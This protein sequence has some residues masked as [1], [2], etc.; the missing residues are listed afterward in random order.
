MDITLDKKSSTEASIKV[1]LKESDYQPNVEEKVKDYARKANIKGFRPGKVPA[2]LIKKMYGKSIVVEEVNHILSKSLSEYIKKE[3]I[4]LIGEP[5]P[6]MDKAANIDWDN[7]KDFEFDYAIGMV[8]KFTYDLSKKQKVAS[9]TI[10]LDK[11]GLDETIENVRKQ[12]GTT[13]NPEVSQEGDSFYGELKQVDGDLSNEGL[14]NWDDLD[15]KEQKTFKGAKPG[16]V[17]EFNIEK[18][19]KDHHTAAHLLEIG[20]DKAKELKGKFQFTIKNINRTEPA[21]MNQDFFDKVFG[22]GAVNNEEE[23][24]NKVKQTVE[25]NYKRETEYFLDHSLREHFVK[26]TKIDIPENFLKDW[27]LRSNEG[28][29]TQE[30]VDR[31]FD[32]YVKS[33]KWDL[34]KNKVAED[35]EIKVE[36]DEVVDKAKSMILQQLGGPGAA[37]QL[38]DHLDSFANNYLQA[39]NGQNYMKV[40]SE[41]RDEK[42]LS[43]IKEQVTL[44]EKKVDLEE[45]KKIASN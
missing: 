43:F 4:Q 24:N 19:F 5:L 32:E 10:E 11:K 14:I 23:F 36:N 2:S 13:T 44:A 45:F 20:H 17:I 1:T 31:E 26:N 27:L 3:D 34:I 40:Y 22:K 28:K 15:K 35:N 41:V 18:A 30:D 8:D 42:I 21:E 33:L 7:Q 16:D 12:F 39:E 38:K 37:E 29:V 25:E 6:D 9:Y